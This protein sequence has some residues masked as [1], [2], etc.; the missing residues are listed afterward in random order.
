MQVIRL[1]NGKSYYGYVKEKRGSMLLLCIYRNHKNKEKE[2]FH[3]MFVPVKNI[4]SIEG[5]C[6]C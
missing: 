6:A 5:D 1:T 4:L 2:V 3:P